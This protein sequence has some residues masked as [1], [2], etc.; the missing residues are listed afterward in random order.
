MREILRAWGLT[1][2]LAGLLLA[3]AGVIAGV[4]KPVLERGKGERCVEDTAYMRRYHM[5]LLKHH[6][7]DTLRR[8]IRTTKHSLKGCVDC[9]ASSKTGSVASSK[10]DFCMACHTYASVKLDCW[11]CHASKPM[12]KTTPAASTP[13]VAPLTV[14]LPG[15]QQP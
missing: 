4:S 7:D 5:E 13:R 2:L 11:D 8:G 14:G 15:G 6:R 9:H 3:P 10:E 12:K 1:A